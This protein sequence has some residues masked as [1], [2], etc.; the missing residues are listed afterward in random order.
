MFNVW[1]QKIS[2]PPP[3]PTEDHW[4]FRG[5]GGVHG[6]LFSKGWQTMYKT[7]KATYDRSETQKHTY[8]CCF[9]TKVG[10]PGHWHEVINIISFNV[11]VFLWVSQRYNLQKNDVSLERSRQRLK[12]GD[13]YITDV[14]SSS[15]FHPTNIKVLSLL[16]TE[17]PFSLPWH[18]GH[19]FLIGFMFYQCLLWVETHEK[20]DE[21]RILSF[22]FLA[23]PSQ[24]PATWLVNSAIVKS[25]RCSRN[26]AHWHVRVG[27][28]FG[29]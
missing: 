25:W 13:T 9:E 7:L 23:W 14:L 10:T 27:K 26:L 12:M 8:A 4:K 1:L 3:P 24:G 18:A 17:Y 15:G 5:G 29:P 16:F 22:P 21:T 19:T 28:V 6:K 11:S 2:I 20:C